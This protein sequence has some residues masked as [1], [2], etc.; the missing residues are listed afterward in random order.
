MS[1][2][3]IQ[4][5]YGLWARHVTGL[6]VKNCS[7]NYEQRDS[8]HVLYLDDVAGAQLS[9][10]KAVMAKD[11]RSAI[12]MKNAKDVSVINTIYYVDAWGN[13]RAELKLSR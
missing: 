4:P 5:S 8:R 2:L 1:N 9:G 3:K 10:I 11:G 12:G 13:S 6:T 7:F